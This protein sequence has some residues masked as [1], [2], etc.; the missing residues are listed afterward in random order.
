MSQQELGLLM[1]SDPL[2][3]HETLEQLA[4]MVASMVGN[5]V[6]IGFDPSVA[7]FINNDEGLMAS[8]SVTIPGRGRR[9]KAR[10]YTMKNLT[11]DRIYQF[12]SI[13]A[14]ALY[15]YVHIWWIQQMNAFPMS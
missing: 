8:L 7:R 5:A 9:S 13:P 1:Y 3:Y 2:N 11:K 10:E 12:T 14:E 4:A 6:R 15:L